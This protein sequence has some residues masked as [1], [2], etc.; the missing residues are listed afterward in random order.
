MT[1]R[2]YWV[3]SINPD[4]TGNIDTFG[5]YPDAWNYWRNMNLTPN[6][7]MY[8]LI[9]T[10]EVAEQFCDEHNLQFINQTT[11]QRK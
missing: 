8:M 4:L 7:M 11:Q 2:P 10:P 5:T 1:E 6:G 9:E 3:I